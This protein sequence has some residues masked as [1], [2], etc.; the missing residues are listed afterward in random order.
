MKHLFRTLVIFAFL[1]LLIKAAWFTLSYLWLPATGVDEKKVL[2]TTALFY[3]V[4]LGPVVKRA[5][6]KPKKKRV[7]VAPVIRSKIKDIKLL[8]IYNSTDATVVT[9]VYKKKTKVLTRGEEVNGFVLEGARST[10]AIFSKDKKTYKVPLDKSKNE[11]TA[12]ARIKTK[13]RIKTKKLETKKPKGKIVVDGNNR[14]V[15]RSLVEYYTKNM[16]KMMNDIDVGEVRNGN[17]LEGFRIRFVRRNSDFA[18]LGVRR[19]DV[20]K[21]INGQEMNSYGAALGIYKNMQDIENLSLVVQR[22]NKEVE[23][24]YEIN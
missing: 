14:I 22:G 18:K 20:I 16:K 8:A 4:K 17:D 1:A 7:V 23:L 3:P 6:K 5:I 9:V 10:Y 24:E 21:S 11:K 2:S 19:D 15:D 13:T 12:T